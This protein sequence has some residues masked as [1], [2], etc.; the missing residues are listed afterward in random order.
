MEELHQLVIVRNPDGG[1]DLILMSG[2]E[3]FDRREYDIVSDIIEDL[4]D[5][6]NDLKCPSP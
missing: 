2:T 3:T 5:L 1:V 4:S 6:I